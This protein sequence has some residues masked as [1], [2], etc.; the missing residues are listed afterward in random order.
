V[1][2]YYEPTF[3]GGPK[4]GGLVPMPYWVMEKITLVQKLPNGNNMLYYYKLDNETK[5]YIYDGQTEEDN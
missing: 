5:D 3:I 1:S 4:D 2:E